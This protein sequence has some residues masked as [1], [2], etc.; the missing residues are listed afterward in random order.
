VETTNYKAR[1]KE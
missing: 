1:W